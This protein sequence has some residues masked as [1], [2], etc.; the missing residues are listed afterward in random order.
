[1]EFSGHELNALQQM[2]SSSGWAQA[3]GNGNGGGTGGGQAGQEIQTRSGRISRPPPPPPPKP[4]EANGSQPQP[5]APAAPQQNGDK[6]AAPEAAEPPKRGRG[7]PRLPEEDRLSRLRARNKNSGRSLSAAVR[8]T[9]LTPA[10]ISR[11]RRKQEEDDMRNEL[12]TRRRECK[13]L[14]DR[15]HELEAQ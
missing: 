7:R 9:E 4:D 3:N 12:A 15:C 14:E 11:Q 1:M 5:A 2:S 6:P 8:L 10:H 13:E